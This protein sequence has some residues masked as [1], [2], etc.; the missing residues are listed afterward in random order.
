MAVA[1][2]G[3]LRIGGSFDGDG[4]V[5][6]ARFAIRTVPCP[7]T[8]NPF[9]GGCASSG[10]ANTLSAA[11]LP[12]VNGTFHANGT[13]LPATAIVLAVTSFTPVVPGFPLAAVFA[14]ALPGCNLHVAPDIL[15]TLLTTTGTAQSTLALPNV[16]PIVGLSFYH[17]MVPFEVDALGAIA[18]ITASNTLQATVGIL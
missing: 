10:G 12:W 11:A 18:A 1:G 15:E 9:A 13:G 16:P 3:T 5:P 6:A 17:Q 14:E 4:N 8:S 2:D 7:A